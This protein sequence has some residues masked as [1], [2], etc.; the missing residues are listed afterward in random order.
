MSQLE[1]SWK[2]NTADFLISCELFTQFYLSFLT[3]IFLVY[4]AIK[5]FLEK[6]SNKTESSSRIDLM[7]FIWMSGNFLQGVSF[8]AACRHVLC[9]DESKYIWKSLEEI[10]DMKKN[11]HE[12]LRG[13]TFLKW[14]QNWFYQTVWQ[15]NNT[16]IG[17]ALCSEKS[18]RSIKRLKIGRIDRENGR[19]SNTYLTLSMF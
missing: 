6:A 10:W 1:N 18:F 8:S 14:T 5:N 7:L 17:N 15:K 11:G 9:W 3:L 19:F 4:S 13:K 2:K 16:I 12:L